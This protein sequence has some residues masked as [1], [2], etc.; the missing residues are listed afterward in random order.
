MI[1]LKKTLPPLLQAVARYALCTILLT[2]A[3]TLA[4]ELASL[5]PQEWVTPRYLA[6]L[7]QFE[8]EGVQPQI[9]NR[10]RA[11]ARLNNYSEMLILHYSASMNKAADPHAALS[12]SAWVTFDGQVDF[13][14]YGRAV[15]EGREPTNFYTRYWQGFRAVVRPLL[16][17]VDYTNMR[18]LLMWVFFLLMTGCAVRLYRVAHHLSVPLVFVFSLLL[19]NPIVVST[20][21]QYGICFLLGLGGLFL[22][23]R[24]K[25]IQNVPL[26]FFVLGA[27][28]QYFDFYTA[29]IITLCYPLLGLLCMRSLSMRFDL[30]SLWR[31]ALGSILAWLCAYGLFWLIKL[32]LSSLVAPEGHDP[33]SS[34]F[35]SFFWR[36]G[37]L[38]S[39]RADME[40][41]HFLTAF[42]ACVTVLGDLVLYSAVLTA[43]VQLVRSLLQRPS[44]SQWLRILPLV[45]VSLLP[46]VWLA[47]AAQPTTLHSYFQYRLTAPIL[48]GLML[49]PGL[50]GLM[51]RRAMDTTAEKEPHI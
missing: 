3:F 27:S 16:C 35:Q 25:G 1:K 34:A 17:L 44:S 46:L 32:L 9:L 38:R 33:L 14:E 8:E 51:N 39:D 21:F 18:T 6:S 43:L 42:T 15:A 29:P 4:L 5:L 7:E 22:V 45:F 2:L 23:L 28:T 47:V 24:P 48:F 36:V 49:F 30:R 40:S 10:S 31:T 13:T 37:V 26:F 12:N 11:D 41:Y 50:P 19:Y 20:S